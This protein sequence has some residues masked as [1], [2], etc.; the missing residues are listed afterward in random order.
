MQGLSKYKL[1]IVTVLIGLI[2]NA[3]LDVPLMIFFD[4]IGLNVSYGA[5]IAAIIG[6][7]FSILLSMNILWRKYNF[8]FRQT[9][10]RLP[11]YILSYILFIVVILIM[12]LFIP[13]NLSGRFI[14]IPIL[15][16]YGIVSFAVYIYINYKNG[17]L[18]S[19]FGSKIE[20]IGKKIKI[21]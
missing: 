12:K 18:V 11:K 19:V 15:A 6:Y 9:I 14:Q 4:G 17:N 8:K 10:R 20:N 2:T 7:S 13:I 21:K 1:V 16:I 5:V 3:L